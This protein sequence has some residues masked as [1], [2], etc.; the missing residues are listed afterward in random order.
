[1]IWTCGHG[2]LGV[3]GPMA[4]AGRGLARLGCSGG[5]LDGA[6]VVGSSTQIWSGR[7]GGRLVVVVSAV[8]AGVVVLSWGGLVRAVGGGAASVG[9]GRR[10]SWAALGTGGCL[11]RG[12]GWWG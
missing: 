3:R 5:W 10:G 7:G 12:I 6:V 1:M 11:C 9:L 2:D 8:V 4:G